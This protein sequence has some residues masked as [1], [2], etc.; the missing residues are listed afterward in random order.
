M[1]TWL[2]ERNGPIIYYIIENVIKLVIIHV[3]VFFFFGGGKLFFWS[4][5]FNGASFSLVF[6]LAMWQHGLVRRACK[7]CKESV[8]VIIFWWTTI[9][10]M[11]TFGDL[12]LY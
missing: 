5:Y 6:K 10:P 9:V 4:Y 3:S 1:L 8:M 2:F 12:Q 7:F 11:N